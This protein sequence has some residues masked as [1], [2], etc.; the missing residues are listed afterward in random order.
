MKRLSSLFVVGIIF[1]GF[2]SHSPNEISQVKA[3]SLA[4]SYP[5]LHFY[6]NVENDKETIFQDQNFYF[7]VY[8]PIENNNSYFIKATAEVF[9]LDNWQEYFS[10]DFVEN[11]ILVQPGEQVRF[12]PIVTIKTNLSFDYLLHFVF[13][14]EVTQEGNL[15]IGGAAATAI[16]SINADINASRLEIQTTDQGGKE[17]PSYLEIKYSKDKPQG[18]SPYRT[19]DNIRYF[20]DVVPQGYYWIKAID[21]ETNITE[22]MQF[23]LINDTYFNIKY[24]IIAF[25]PFQI[26]APRY[27][28]ENMLINYTVVNEYKTL[29]SVSIRIQ[30]KKGNTTIDETNNFLNIFSRGNYQGSLNIS[31][32]I[33]QTGQY[34]IQG[35]IYVYDYQYLNHS[36]S[37]YLDMP[38]W[39]EALDITIELLPYIVFGVISFGIGIFVMKYSNRKKKIVP[40]PIIT[41]KEEPVDL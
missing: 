27:P 1:L 14:P 36:E 37:V 6:L 38:I 7:N 10:F 40:S 33:W 30:V 8:N 18:Y 23:E 25:L 15:L 24:K 19:F 31:N 13:V 21:L 12:F 9:K 29:D 28:E 35:F 32:Y 11:N 26:F 17:R 41:K 2:F 39:K 34:T 20:S 3:D 4:I 22:I 5:S 16:F